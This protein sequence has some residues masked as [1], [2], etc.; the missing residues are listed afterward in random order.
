MVK[1]LKTVKKYGNENFH[2]GTLNVKQYRN[3]NNIK[4]SCQ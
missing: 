4:G 1:W 3:K 2:K